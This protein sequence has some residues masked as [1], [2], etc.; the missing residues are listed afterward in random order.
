MKNLYISGY[1]SY[2][3]NVFSSTDPKVQFIKNCLKKVIIRYIENGLE[4]VLISGQMGAEIW[5]AEAVFDLKEDY[6]ELKL[7][8]LFPFEGF[9]ENWNETNQQV[10]QNLKN[11]ADFVEYT[12]HRPYQSPK[13]LKGNQAF[14]MEHTQGAIL[15]Y[16]TEF[17]G[18]P[19]YLYRM[20]QEKQETSEYG[21][22][23]ITF[24]ELQESVQ[25]E[26]EP[27]YDF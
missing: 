16:D 5:A 7:A 4:W 21:L 12:S 26:Q 22:E 23:L 9:G 13:Q 10:L 18:K 6:P 24:D 3:M 11:K 8:V 14:L 2:E 27:F 19:K 20:I 1:R 15:L 25:E 17:E